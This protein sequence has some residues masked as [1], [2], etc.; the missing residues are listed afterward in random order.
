MKKR[1]SKGRT[2]KVVSLD[3]LKQ[4]NLNAAGLD[5][6]D[7]EIWACVPEGRDDSSVRV[8]GTFTVDL[9]ALA[10]WLAECGVD[11]V[12]IV[13]QLVEAIPEDEK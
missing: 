2:K 13:R 3:S 11:T 1:Q 12:A 4:L 8:F 9:Y 6:G 7:D 10:D 5:V